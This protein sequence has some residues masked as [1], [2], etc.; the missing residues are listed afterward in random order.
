MSD[1]Y[2]LPITAKLNGSNY[3]SWSCKLK[4]ILPE[5]GCQG[6]IDG[7]DLEPDKQ[8]TLSTTTTIGPITKAWKSWKWTDQKAQGLI[9]LTIEQ[10]EEEHFNRLI[11]PTAKDL[12]DALKAGHKSLTPGEGGV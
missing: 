10:S 7:W 9:K 1:T 12:W 3:I 4:N 2:K 5:R 11:D 6:I 8:E